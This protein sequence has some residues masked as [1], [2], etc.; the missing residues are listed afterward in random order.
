MPNNVVSLSSNI[1]QVLPVPDAPIATAATEV[2]DNS[3]TANWREVRNIDNYL[4]DVSET[5]TFET[6]LPNFRDVEVKE[7]TRI[8]NQLQ[9]G[10]AYFYRLRAKNRSGNSNYSNVIEAVTLPTVPQNLNLVSASLQ[11][12]NISW[13]ASRS[14]L[15]LTY[16]VDVS[17]NRG[18]T[19][20]LINDRITN[21]PSLSIAGTFEAGRQYFVRVKARHSRGGESAYSEVLTITMI[22]PT[23][24]NLAFSQITENSFNLNWNS[25]TGAD[26]YE[27]VLAT[28]TNFN[29]LVRTITSTNANTD[30]G[31]L[32]SLQQYF[33]RV[34]AVNKTGKSDNSATASTITLP[35]PITANIARNVGSQQFTATWNASN[36]SNTYLLE[37]ARNEAFTDM[38]AGFAS[39]EISNALER[40]VNW[41]SSERELY[42]IIRVIATVQGQRLISRPSNVQRVRIL[43]V[44]FGFRVSN[45]TQTSFTLDWNAVEG[46][47]QYEVSVSIDNFTTT[48]P[49]YNATR[50]SAPQIALQR[51]EANRTYQIRVRATSSEGA[52]DN[53]NTSQLTLPPFPDEVFMRRISS[54]RTTVIEWQYF[55]FAFA[56][57]SNLRFVL[58]RS[59]VPDAPYRPI[60]SPLSLSD[61]RSARFDDVTG[62]QRLQA[63]YR[64]K[65]S[66]EAGE[67]IFNIPNR[68]VTATEDEFFKDNVLLYPNPTNNIF[69]LKL[70]ESNTKISKLR[71]YDNVGKL[72]IYWENIQINEHTQFDI[73]I[74]T[75]GRYL[76][77]VVNSKQQTLYL[78]LI[79]E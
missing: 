28:N 3:F 59:D 14:E 54:A 46:A 67:V 21:S 77:E 30:I 44:P 64:L 38:L 43:A 15:P 40:L 27:I 22:P 56:R 34:R 35:N 71:V 7:T 11:Q 19:N 61:A 1:I 76:I 68:I 31:N 50:V 6:T 74:L 69:Q 29:P 4:L 65:I 16:L 32:S 78:P 39:V 37:V 79:K 53:G 33:V 48:L 42:Y 18:F 58:E 13:T 20:N 70:R 36:Q 63:G 55:S 49:A 75:S 51:L 57:V 25:A 8:I 5:Q 10:K 2:K 47:E 72:I 60:S 17:T 9:A 41:Q 52:S 24:Q 26:S 45:L 12:I 23:P 66:N 62:T 73:S